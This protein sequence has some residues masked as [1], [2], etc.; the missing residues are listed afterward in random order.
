MSVFFWDHRIKV[1]QE[2]L[3]SGL[4]WFRDGY[5]IMNLDEEYQVPEVYPKNFILHINRSEIK[6]SLNLLSSCLI[7]SQGSR[8]KTLKVTN[9]AFWK[10][11]SGFH[12]PC[13]PILSVQF[14]IAKVPGFIFDILIIHLC[15]SLPTA[16]E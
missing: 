6:I 5:Y 4:V 3:R 11:F 9:D 15:P 13:L 8:D 12:G 16:W 14:S 1:K 7:I 2:A 10:E